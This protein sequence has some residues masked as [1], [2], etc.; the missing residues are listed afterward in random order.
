MNYD[1]RKICLYNNQIHSRYYIDTNGVVYTSLSF[2]TNRIMI[3]NE[4]KPINAIR[5]NLILN[6]NKTNKMIC[7]I[8]NFENYYLLYNG[9]ILQ[10]L[11]TM[12]DSNNSVSINLVTVSDKIRKNFSV[13]RLVAQCFIG[14]IKDKEVHHIDRDRTN[15]KVENLK[16]M[17]FEEHR[18]KE[19][20]K[21]NHN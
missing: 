19:N 21:I 18:G 7:K 12:V 11:K 5:N 17:T 6:L 8:P 3:N 9:E 4:R 1:I 16:I 20:Y 2:K 10:R 15:N 13:P 14:D